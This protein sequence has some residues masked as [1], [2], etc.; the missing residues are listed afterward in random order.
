MEPPKD[1][2]N[3]STAREPSDAMEHPNGSQREDVRRFLAGPNS[4]TQEFARL[5]RIS[6][7]FLRGFRE[8]HFLGPCV[9]V[10]GSARFKEDHPYYIM[11]REVGAELSRVGFTVMT[12]GGPGVMEAANR[13][14]RDV[15][16]PSIGCNIELPHEQ[17]PN[18]YLDKVVS[19]R[20]FFVRKV[21]LVKY[22]YAFVTLPGGFGTMDEIFETATLIQT[23]KIKNFP[24]VVMG[25]D[26]WA[27]LIEFMRDT[28]VNQKTIDEHDVDDILVTDSPTEAAHHIRDVTMERFGLKYG[29]PIKPRWWLGERMLRGVEH[30][31]RRRSVD[32]D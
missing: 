13:G 32:I 25:R 27:P 18:P 17:E 4:R 22:S 14:A 26:Y 5:F 21:M 19:F 3:V 9:T 23:A 28:M 7:E 2:K 31:H 20:Y 6:A 29:P 15:G 30:F 1:L 24:I 8:L 16:G 10:F 11:A 12:G